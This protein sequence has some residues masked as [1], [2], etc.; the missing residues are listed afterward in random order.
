MTDMNPLYGRAWVEPHLFWFIVGAL[1]LNWT[2]YRLSERRERKW[3]EEEMRRHQDFKRAM[4]K[5]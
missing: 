3:E 2:L 1:I 4:D 5:K